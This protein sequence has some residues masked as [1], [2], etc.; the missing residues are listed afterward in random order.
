MRYGL[1]SSID[2]RRS[3]GDNLAAI[4]FA[5]IL[6]ERLAL[7]DLEVSDTQRIF[8]YRSRPEV[9]RFQSWGTQ[10]ADGIQLYLRDLSKTEPGRPGSW[11]QIGIIL[12]SSG[13]LIGDCGF[14]VLETEPR[15]ADV[16]IALA[17]EFQGRGY[18]TETLRALLDYLLVALGKDRVFGSV[19]P[20]NVRSMRLLQRV[21]MR[22]EAHRVKSL[23]FKG[24]WVDD[25]IFAIT[26][27]EWKSRLNN[28]P[29]R[30][31]D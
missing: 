30:R 9:S 24:E 22:K 17:P 18:A 8:E 26:A 3:S 4:V 14:Q 15:Q 10:S 25:A 21:G 19:D 7:R 13:E 29:N 6:T 12:R 31:T 27:S 5:E 2:S 23:W 11:Y 1:V 16:G 28:A 20:R